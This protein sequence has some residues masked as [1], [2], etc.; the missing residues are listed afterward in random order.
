MMYIDFFTFEPI[1]ELFPSYEYF[2]SRKE[3][4]QR[5][6][7]YCEKWEDMQKSD[8]CHSHAGSPIGIELKPYEYKFYKSNGYELNKISAWCK[9]GKE[10]HEFMKNIVPS[11]GYSAD[12]VE[13]EWSCEY[14]LLGQ[15]TPRAGFYKIIEKNNDGWVKCYYTR[16]RDL[17]FLDELI[18]IDIKCLYNS[19]SSRGPLGKN[20]YEGDILHIKR[21]TV[22]KYFYPQSENGITI[23]YRV[24]WDKIFNN[25]VPTAYR[26]VVSHSKMYDD[27][28]I[29]MIVRGDYCHLMDGYEEKNFLF[30]KENISESV[31]VSKD[32]LDQLVYDFNFQQL[33]TLRH[34][35]LDYIDG[36]KELTDKDEEIIQD[37]CNKS[38]IINPVAQM[39]PKG[40]S[41]LEFEP[42]K[43]YAKKGN[44]FEFSIY[45][46]LLTIKYEH[47]YF[48]YYYNGQPL[49][50]VKIV[51][52]N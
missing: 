44:I 27:P 39:S 33:E 25:Y 7:E 38:P 6:R 10:A 9:S 29:S 4:D 43:F 20:L 46:Q 35:L 11:P 14:V 2:P 51:I 26:G 41:T 36:R 48:W 23:A 28:I 5:W 50:E 40:I 49:N 34:V 24:E 18:T 32:K 47:G 13:E 30:I 19:W 15:Y 45:N 3:F 22:V 16:S 37:I 42:M 12:A 52:I 8:P 17:D 21:T 1:T 31:S